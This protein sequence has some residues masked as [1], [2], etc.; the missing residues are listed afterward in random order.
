MGTDANA[1]NTIIN[2]FFIFFSLSRRQPTAFWAR[3]KRKP[4]DEADRLH[5]VD[6]VN[7]EVTSKKVKT[8]Q[9]N[10]TRQ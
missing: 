1:N 6:E 8:T 7:Y 2:I 5:P 4:A 10:A 9:T 3:L